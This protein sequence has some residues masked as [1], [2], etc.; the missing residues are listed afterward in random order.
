MKKADFDRIIV[1]T[2][3]RMSQIIVWWQTN[4]PWLSEE[5]FN[6]PMESG[7]IVMKEEGIDI[8]FESRDDGLV[9][10][11]VYPAHI[12]EAAMQFELNPITTTMSG[13]RFANKMRNQEEQLLKIVFEVDNTDVKESV[14]YL[15]LMQFATHYEEIIQIDEKQS[16]RRTRH[17]AKRLRK[18]PKK[19]LNL[20]KKTYVIKEF[21]PSDLHR[22]GEKRGYT[23][24]DHEV[25]VRGFYRMMKSG[26]KVWV[27]P[28]SR[29]KDKGNKQPKEYKV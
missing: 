16:V 1:E 21:S 4:R 11:S 20:V 25:Q 22:F 19:P 27:K 28:F 10:I 23:K 18:N 7:L 3:E 2:N 17:E 15:A 14:K 9:T 13:H 12:E 24:P 29:Y 6:A 26:K 8:G 5:D